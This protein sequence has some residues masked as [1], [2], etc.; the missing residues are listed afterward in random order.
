M[1][2]AAIRDTLYRKSHQIC[3]KVQSGEDLFPMKIFTAPQHTR[4]IL[5]L[6]SPDK[7]FRLSCRAVLFFYRTGT[8]NLS[9]NHDKEATRSVIYRDNLFLNAR[10]QEA[11]QAAHDQD[12]QTFEKYSFYDAKMMEDL[13]YKCEHLMP[14]EIKC[15]Y[16]LQHYYSHG[17]HSPIIRKYVRRAKIIR[18]DNWRDALPESV[19]DIEM[20]TVYRG[21]I[22]SIE[23]APLSISWSLSYD[24]AEWFAHRSEL[25]HRCSCHVYQGTIHA[26]KVIAYLPERSEFEIIQH[27][28]V[29]DV[30]EI[31]PLRGY[32][33]PFNAFKSSKKWVHNEEESNRYFNEWYQ[34]QNC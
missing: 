34:S 21:G 8:A 20:F 24:V 33:P 31:T 18:P 23:R 13:L 19:R 7:I 9:T 5:P 28:N 32:S 10:F 30:Q 11:V 15:R 26:D 17:D 14:L 1:T 29:K 22:G 25:F 3:R 27:R 2:L 16:A 12:W 6:T 4:F